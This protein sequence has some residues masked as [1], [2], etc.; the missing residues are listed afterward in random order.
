MMLC[1]LAIVEPFL[2]IGVNR[3]QIFFRCRG[4]FLFECCDEMTS[5]AV[6]DFESNFIDIIRTAVEQPS[7][8]IHFVIEQ[9]TVNRIAINLFETHFEFF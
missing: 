4:E 6:A 3:H 8:I 5:G 7:R 1:F 2:G 9:K